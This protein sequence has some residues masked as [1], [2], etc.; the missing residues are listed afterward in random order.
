MM[1]F[2]MNQTIS[3][4][5]EERAVGDDAEDLGAE[6]GVPLDHGTMKVPQIPASRWTGMAPTTSSIFS[7]SSIGTANTTIAPPTAPM[8]SGLPTDGAS[9]SAVIDTRPARAPFSTMVRS[10]FL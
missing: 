10:T 5:S 7:L 8:I 9:G 6:G 1:A 4:T 3:D 2:R